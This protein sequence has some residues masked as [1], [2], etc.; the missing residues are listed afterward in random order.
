M[1]NFRHLLNSNTVVQN[2]TFQKKLNEFNDAGF[3]DEL[4]LNQNVNANVN[5]NS[6]SYSVPI[7]VKTSSNRV[8]RILEENKRRWMQFIRQ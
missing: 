3:I 2:P 5:Q 7:P 4:R 8:A 1:F 6:S